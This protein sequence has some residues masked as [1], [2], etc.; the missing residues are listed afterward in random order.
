MEILLNKLPAWVEIDLDNLTWNIRKTLEFLDPRVR[1]LLTVKA[2]A[3]GHGAVPLARAAIDE[4]IH[5]LGVA[6]IDE[7]IE[8]REAGIG[9]PVLVLSPILDVE[10][11]AALEHGLA[12]TIS[13]REF[14][15][16]A[17]AAAQERKATLGVHVEVD[18]GM[19]RTG[20][21][22]GDAV[23]SVV[24]ITELP[25]LRLDG[26]YTH[27]PSSD[28]DLDFSVEQLRSFNEIVDALRGEGISPEYV[29]AANSAAVL[30]LP[31][32]HYNLVRPGLMIYGHRPST[33]LSPKLDLR[34]VMSF[35]SKLI[36]VRDLEAGA[37]V[38]YGRTFVTRHRT[39]MGIL[40]VGYG[41]GYNYRLSNRARAL[42]RGR[43]VPV[44]GRVTMDM[45]MIDLTELENPRVGEEVVLFGPQ[46]EERITLEEVAGWADTLNYEIL[47]GISKRVVRVY[48]FQGQVAGYK[49][50]LGFRS[51]S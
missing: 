35:K 32:S 5:M 41:H 33:H 19:G 30:N 25:S 27:F 12:V 4:G 29:H 18:T 1:I 23:R 28:V 6:T 38:S 2:D 50:L 9:A 3:Y 51:S 34:P 42:F 26:I 49:T 8:L 16:S 21:S 48:L 15:E 43:R 24:G 46:D 37:S 11:P 13:S 17:S 20:V 40:P 39:R 14:A 22:R 10:V 45:T 36:Q 7:G 47:C 44:L 31:G